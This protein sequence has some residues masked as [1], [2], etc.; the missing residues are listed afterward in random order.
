[1]IYADFESVWKRMESACYIRNWSATLQNLN[2]AKYLLETEKSL[3]DS[4]VS[5]PNYVGNYRNWLKD[6][7]EWFQNHCGSDFRRSGTSSRTKPVTLS[8]VADVMETES[9]KIHN[10]RFFF[11][12]PGEKYI[13]DIE[14]PKILLKTVTTTQQHHH[15]SKLISNSVWHTWHKKVVLFFFDMTKM[16]FVTLQGAIRTVLDG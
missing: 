16:L 9:L 12:F 5:Y 14:F 3:C 10:W 7:I 2:K 1:M 13:S 6:P 8:P 15:P 4:N 11:Y